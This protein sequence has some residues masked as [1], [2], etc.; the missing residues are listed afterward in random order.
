MDSE[1][2]DDATS[3]DGGDE[4]EEPDHMEIDDDDDD[5][6]DQS[7]EEEQE[8]QT[9][10]VTLHYRKEAPGSS[11]AP[12]PDKTSI[13]SATHQNGALLADV[14]TPAVGAAALST[15]QPVPPL[16]QVIPT[17]IPNGFSVHH[18]E[19]TASP[20]IEQQLPVQGISATPKQ[21]GFTS[22]PTPPYSAPEEALKQEQPQFHPAKP[23]A[24]LPVTTHAPNW[25]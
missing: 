6:A 20:K 23:E 17:A 1:E 12:K 19:V 18:H 10:V 21:D 25:Q 4:E 15:S 3:W 8:P 16:P 7:S 2:D 5:L 24:Q 9:L 14:E 22:A 11:S 13:D